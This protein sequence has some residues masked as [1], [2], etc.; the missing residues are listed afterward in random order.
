MDAHQL[1]IE[2][3]SLMILA[4]SEVSAEMKKRHN[5]VNAPSP[6]IDLKYCINQNSV[7]FDKLIELIPAKFYLPISDKEKKWPRP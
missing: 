3:A 1:L 5:P 7:F 2:N 4:D 6:D